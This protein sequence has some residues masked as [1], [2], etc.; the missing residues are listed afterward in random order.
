MAKVYT[1]KGVVDSKSL[2]IKDTITMEDTARVIA[3]EW[4]LGEE[5][6]RRDVYVNLLVG[7]AMSGEQGAIGG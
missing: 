1:T 2:T 5:L 6:V 3:T 4:Y 7:L